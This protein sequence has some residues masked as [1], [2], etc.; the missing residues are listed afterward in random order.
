[1]RL[2]VRLRIL[3]G[4][5]A[6]I[7]TLAAANLISAFGLRGLDKAS[8]EIV[9]KTDIVRHVNDYA[10][11][12]AAQ[13]NA[14]RSFA[15]SGREEDQLRLK[16]A[17]ERAE[18]TKREVSELLVSVGEAGTAA[19]IET[20][21]NAFAQ[22]FTA[23]EN[24][25]GN[26]EDALQVVAVG[27]GKLEN[28][29]K[30][31]V[32]FL[33]QK[34]GAASDMAPKFQPVV[35]RFNQASIA[36][37]ASGQLAD[38]DEAI[39]AGEEFDSLI[40]DAQAALRG[41][42]RREMRVLMYARRDGDVIRQSLRAKNA[43]ALALNDAIVQ[44]E[45]AAADIADITG[46]AKQAARNEQGHALDSM[47]VAVS[48]AIEQS[49]I[50]LAIGAVIAALMAW[51][52]GASVAGPLVRITDA[53]SKLAAGDKTT[54]IPG[55]ARSD[56][57]GKMAEAAGVFKDKA[58]ELERLAEEKVETELRMAEAQRAHEKEE[59]RQLE[60]QKARQEQERK[61]RQEMRMKQR[62]QMADVF[63]AGVMRIVETVAN[64]SKDMAG[65]AKSLVGN[66][67]ETSAQVH[68]T[69][70]AT[71]EAAS[72]VQAVAGATEELSVS[73]R[74]VSHELDQSAQVAQSA[75]VEASRTTETVA[76]LSNAASQIGNVVKMIR[77]IADQTNL[78]ALNATIEAARAGEAG[79]GFAV[80]ASEVK[81][82]ASQSSKAT[83]E[84]AAYVEKIQ[85]VSDDASGAIN[86]IGE[87]I[88]QMNDV[89]QSV[90][91]AVHQQSAATGEIA[92]N[93]QHVSASTEQVRGSVAIV[94]AA[95]A[96]TRTMS[97]EMQQ[98][99]EK[100]LTE[101]E[102]LKKE[103][104]RFLLE[105]RDT[106]EEGRQARPSEPGNIHFLRTA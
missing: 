77:D 73:F 100:L 81:N 8:Q 58:F 86:R 76:G 49:F 62:L 27:I 71:D 44:L 94:D 87:I 31:L 45:N 83:E 93:V 52:I 39:R 68:M 102:T 54:D 50:G 14:L 104:E 23:V 15:F 98:N 55:R 101:S 1:M 40:K 20:A 99:A 79:K 4:F 3:L 32:E 18:V 17:Q 103:V 69:Q 38:F 92:M 59:A 19:E 75:V 64:A 28:S 41:T 80:V 70:K 95:A 24:R 9:A 60:E 16:K 88:G 36:Y 10:S 25:L 67:Q 97:G 90:V 72:N 13:T 42:P 48:T 6:V 53:I 7:V 78:L 5:T 89:T 63:E 21:S 105:V 91:A 66:T 34:G 65:A 43:A 56:E 47:M 22:V 57:L 85:L 33:R 2:S 82:L 37:V 96:E 11:D 29:S 74:S 26:E 51:Y 84:I 46:K 12:I 106:S 35:G 61:A 30:L